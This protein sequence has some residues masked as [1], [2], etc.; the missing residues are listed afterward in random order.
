M[1][2]DLLD[3]CK[4]YLE[5]S[6]GV[7]HPNEE[8]KHTASKLWLKTVFQG[9]R[10]E[11]IHFV[12]M[13]KYP[14]GFDRRGGL[15]YNGVFV[16]SKDPKL[17]LLEWEIGVFDLLSERTA[18]VDGP[19][20]PMLRYEIRVQQELFHENNYKYAILRQHAFLETIFR[21]KAGLEQ[22]K[23]R[24]TLNCVYRGEDL[25]STRSFEELSDFDDLR[26]DLAHDWYAYL[27]L[28]KEVIRSSAQDA[29]RVMSK[30]LSEE[31]H[32]TYISY[33][34]NHPSNRLPA[35]LEKRPTSETNSSGRVSVEISCDNCGNKFNPQNHWKRC[36]QCRTKHSYWKEDEG[37]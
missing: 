34:S 28:E 24:H 35:K 19:Y 23:W 22:V 29:L 32:T 17:A 13:M 30:L 6:I 1:N 11:P 36:P 5:I 20:I 4:K 21:R 16:D 15:L 2:E 12:K 33:T 14:I 27:H 18:I 9:E 7:R 26:N 8:E 37:E 10:P 3:A 31:I 25:I